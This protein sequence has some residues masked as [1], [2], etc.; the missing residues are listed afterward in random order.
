MNE[1]LIS[2][3]NQYL[4]E[5][6][7]AVDLLHQAYMAVADLIVSCPDGLEEDVERI[8]NA[9]LKLKYKVYDLPSE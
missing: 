9:V 6:E 5:K 3:Q 2:S 8:A 1:S 4:E 7:K